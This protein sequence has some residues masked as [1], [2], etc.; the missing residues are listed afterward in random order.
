M[1]CK[2]ILSLVLFASSALAF[3]CNDLKKEKYFEAPGYDREGKGYRCEENK[4]VNISVLDFQKFEEMKSLPKFIFELKDL[5]EL[6]IWITKI[7]E[8]PKE[9]SN[10]TNLKLLKIN[11]GRLKSIP[12]E[13]GSLKKLIEL[14]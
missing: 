2:I 14:T 6:E 10:L 12:K 11:E 9:I 3:S 5:E 7:T 1:Y 4:N 13:I 8:I